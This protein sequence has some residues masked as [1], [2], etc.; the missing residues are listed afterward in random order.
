MRE[1]RSA[2][3]FRQ[4]RIALAAALLLPAVALPSWADTLAWRQTSV[5]V[6]RDGPVATRR[7]VA[8]FANGEPATLTV[9]LRPLGPPSGRSV[10]MGSEMNFRFEDGSTLGLQGQTTLPVAPEGGTVRGEST[11]AGKVVSGTGRF[12]GA[13]GS[14]TMRVRTDIDRSADG[15]LGDYFA[16][17]EASF[18]LAK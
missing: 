17:C 11:T 12:N 3:F 9:R 13:T 16:V 6:S 5:L 15:V 4:A 7:G 10:D 8:I 14:F 18:T 2:T 1:T